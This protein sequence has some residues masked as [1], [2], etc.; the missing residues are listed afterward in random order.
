MT[1]PVQGLKT[2]FKKK[3]NSI[4]NRT[5]RQNMLYL[6]K[7]KPKTGEKNG[8]YN[9]DNHAYRVDNLYS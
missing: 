3:Y 9:D 5:N 8:K 6:N 4:K 2:Q 7:N 1:E